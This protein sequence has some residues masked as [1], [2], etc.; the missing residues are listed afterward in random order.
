MQEFSTPGA[1]AAAAI[2]ASSSRAEAV[3]RW[4]ET[5]VVGAAAGHS[6]QLMAVSLRTDTHHFQLDLDD[7]D[8]YQS[9]QPATAQ[10]STS[11]LTVYRGP[12]GS[13]S[14]PPPPSPHPNPRHRNPWWLPWWPAD[15]QDSGHQEHFLVQTRMAHRQGEGLLIDPGAHDDLVG[16]MWVDRF[17]AEARRASQP[18]PTSYRLDRPVVVG[19]VVNGS[20]VANFGVKC[21]IGVAGAQESFEAP[22]IPNSPVPALLGIRSLKQRRA[23]VDCFTGRMY[24]IG[25]G[26]Y[27]LNL[28]PGSRELKL[29]EAHSGHWILPCTDWPSA[30]RSQS[31]ARGRSLSMLQAPSAP[32]E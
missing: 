5:D 10:P 31:S 32:R 24:F 7:E 2:A 8:S 4:L 26:G 11:T 6:S 3:S 30:S 17:S 19:G 12:A 18:E 16:Q 9:R 15:D 25:A 23:L 14:V 27:K 21:A 22:V 20:N 1:A 28:S 13:A 29:E